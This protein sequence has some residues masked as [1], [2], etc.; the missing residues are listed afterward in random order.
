MSWYDDKPW[1]ASYGERP[2]EPVEATTLPETFRRAVDQG[3]DRNA[4]AY[5]DGR[6]TY[7][8]L[9]ELSDGVARHLTQNGFERGDRLALV[10]QNIPQFV[11]ALL[12]AWKAGGIVVPVNPM[13]RER[14]LTHV[15]TD[16]GV[17]AIVCSQRG[18]NAYIGKT[19]SELP[20][21][22]TT[23][24]LEFQTR[25]DER[26]LGKVVR[27]ETPGATELLEAAKTPGP[28]PPEPAF[29]LGDVALISYTSGTSGTPK[30]ATNT[31][32][33]VGT[34]AAGLGSFSGLPAGSTLFGLAPLF[35]ITG[36]VCEVGSAIDIGGTLALAY[37]FEAGVVLDAFLEHEPSYTVG[38]STAYMALMAHPSFSR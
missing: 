30:G 2:V 21:A 24:E 31:H 38:P 37:R 4:I 15:L 27:E 36:M 6:L 11:I 33:N 14:E 28:K 29:A 10:L 9:D 20:I 25:N 12:G 13:Y 32:G 18:W 16:A 7:R 17:K 19:A 23:S 35:H 22:L 8:R 5:F 26:V 34:N 3:P 1:L